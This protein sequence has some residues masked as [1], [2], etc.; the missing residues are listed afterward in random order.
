MRNRQSDFITIKLQRG[1]YSILFA[2]GGTVLIG[3]IGLAIDTSRHMVVIA[4]LQSAADACALSASY[5]LNAAS[6]AIERAH[7]VGRYVGGQ[8]N[9]KN[10]QTN[11]AVITDQDISFS[12]EINGIFKTRSGG[13]STNSR[14]VKCVVRQSSNLNYFLGALNIVAPNLQAVATAT[15]LPAVSTCAIS[16]GACAS[17][18]TNANF[19]WTVGQRIDLITHT[20]NSD[21][22]GGY[23]N[24][25]G[26]YFT[27]AD[28]TGSGR[29]GQSVYGEP[30]TQNGTCDTPTANGTCIGIHTGVLS[31]MVEEWNTRFGVYKGD[32]LTN[33][34]YNA[35]TAVPDR[36]GYGYDSGLNNL[37]NYLNTQVPGHT[38]YQS[39]VPSYTKMTTSQ[40][41][42]YG[43]TNRRLT[44]IPIVNCGASCATA[45]TNKQFMPVV[46]WA[47]VLLLTPWRPGN[48]EPAVEYVDNAKNATSPCITSGVPGGVDTNGP[49][50]PALV[51]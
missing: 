36:T 46:G 44:A 2:V 13:A 3:F 16:M 24:L 7:S 30:L 37:S 41:A 4:E 12:T 29:T 10:F 19:G 51:Q 15:V 11:Q 33:T 32:V 27:W 17:N 50:V 23:N 18:P 28:V 6:D 31:S 22:S 43:A 5:E 40:H 48:K 39:N 45:S 34:P 1:V 21:G 42:Q 49:L 35:T 38:S 25:S 20:N 9:F 8:K 47:C 14:F 26:G